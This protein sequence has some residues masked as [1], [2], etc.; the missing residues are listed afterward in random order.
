MALKVTCGFARVAVRQSKLLR[1]SENEKSAQKHRSV[2]PTV[3][4]EAF[5][6]VFKSD[7]TLSFED[8]CKSASHIDKVINGWMGSKTNREDKLKFLDHFKINN[9]KKLGSSEKAEHTMHGLC[10]GCCTNHKPFW[11][12]YNKQIKCPK[13][14][15]ALEF[16]DLNCQPTTFMKLDVEEEGA[17]QLFQQADKIC[18]RQYKRPLS[19]ILPELN[20]TSAE[21]ERS[22]RRKTMCKAR[23]Q[24]QKA[25]KRNNKDLDITYGSG[26]SLGSRRVRRLAEEFENRHD[27]EERTK[28]RKEREAAGKLKPKDRLGNF[29]TLCNF[30]KENLKEEVLAYE[31]GKDVNWTQLAIKHGVR[32]KDGNVPGNAGQ[33]VKLWL[34]SEGIDTDRF[35]AS[36]THEVLRKARIR[37]DS[38]PKISVPKKRTE[39]QISEQLRVCITEGE[40][41]IGEFIVPKQYKTYF[42]NKETNRIETQ[43]TEI[44]GRKRPLQE[45]RED[46]LRK[47]QPFLRE[48]RDYGSMT[49]EQLVKR[50]EELGEETSGESEDELREHLYSVENTRFESYW[51]DGASMANHGHILYLVAT[52]YDPAVFLT[53]A[54]YYQKY[55]VKLNVQAMVERPE[56]YLIAR[57]GG[58][59]AEQLLYAETRRDDLPTLSLP[60]VSSDGRPIKDRLRFCK[61]DQPSRG[62]EFGKQRVGF[63]SC[64]C[65]ADMRAVDD[66]W[67]CCHVENPV[68]DIKDRQ[69][70]IMEGPVTS[71]KASLTIPDPFHSMTKEELQEE[72][73]YRGTV[74]YSS[75][76]TMTKKAL[77]DAFK[78][79]FHG[80][81]RVPTL[82]YQKPNQSVEELNLQY[83]EETASE[84]MHDLSN[85]TKNLLSELP[86]RVPK[87]VSETIDTVKG[88]LLNKDVVR[89]SDL[90]LA[91]L[92]L[93][94][95]LKEISEVSDQTLKLIETLAN[96]Q[97]LCYA[98]AEERSITSVFRMTNQ[99]VLHHLLMKECLPGPPKTMTTRK[100]W[101]HY[102]HSL[103]DHIPIVFR[104]VATSSTMAENE[105]RQ[106]SSLKRITKSSANYSKPGHIIKNLFVRTHYQQKLQP[107]SSNHQINKISQAAKAIPKERTRIPINL[108]KKYPRD[109]QTYCERI[110]D[111]LLPGYGVHWHIEEDHVVLHDAP[112]D[113]PNSV[114]GPKLHHF[115]S[116]TLK[117]EHAY[118]QQKWQECIQKQVP[119]PLS[120]LWVYEGQK[121]IKKFKTPYL[122]PGYS[123][124]PQV[125]HNLPFC[126]DGEDEVDEEERRCEP[127]AE[128]TESGAED[129]TVVVR[130]ERLDPE[131]DLEEV[132]TSSETRHMGSCVTSTPSRGYNIPDT[133]DRTPSRDLDVSVPS[134]PCHTDTVSGS[135]STP[136]RS[137][138]I[139]TPA[140]SSCISTPAS[141]SSTMLNT[142]IPTPPNTP[143]VPGQDRNRDESKWKTKMGSALAVVLGDV[144]I[145]RRLDSLK[146]KLK[147]SGSHNNKYIKVEYDTHIAKVSSS[148]S[149]VLHEDRKEFQIWER[150]FMT[151]KGRLPTAIDV[152]NSE[153]A[154]PKQK[155]IR[156]TEHLLRSFGVNLHMM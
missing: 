60:V 117:K 3:R 89:A 148:L 87:E 102:M 151:E 129:D 140:S 13:T 51:E 63:Y 94:Q 12:L 99:I 19:E 5:N 107:S 1:V 10:K 32:G 103:R 79:T 24:I 155:R 146:A 83:L 8:F 58:S 143:M 126:Q 136:A 134:T 133:P 33:L 128:G 149:K 115:R 30:D 17:R 35:K 36:S 122:D 56:I 68:S 106:F 135:I 34:Q 48:P 21:Q 154:L 47:Q 108:L 20:I 18:K 42:L 150:S 119:M 44:E 67:K 101:G 124:E 84:P 88:H 139:S 93:Y 116:T 73:T 138:S 29:G 70:F 76:E 31:D 121:L 97:Q 114:H 104:I 153:V 75:A 113:K 4:Y 57:C 59:D 55:K 144:A 45:I 25:A 38:D 112:D 85:H 109:A 22:K 96:M 65:P 49:T 69:S 77:S 11:N 27:A 14:R 53:N 41:P 64:T 6:E 74:D 120:I 61:G 92:V 156:L 111:F 142:D 145:V 37:L 80:V 86:S 110:S 130:M 81:K 43:V 26:E 46:L 152:R 98:D 50:L 141:S 52:I 28:R 40:V 127:E 78:E 71:Q 72:L 54:E 82:L 105:E 7:T 9:W 15:K 131:P 118:L 125:H 132:G 62:F 90:R 16:D 2:C 39:K 137:S 147:T 91:L 23:E 95:Q 66:F 100:L 123:F